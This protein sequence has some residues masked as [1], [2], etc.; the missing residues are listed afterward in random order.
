MVRSFKVI[1][2]TIALTQEELRKILYS[3]SRSSDLPIPMQ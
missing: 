2:K 1:I 3:H